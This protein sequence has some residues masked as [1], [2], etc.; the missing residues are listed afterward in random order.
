MKA[1]TTTFLIVLLILAGT[2]LAAGSLKDPVTYLG[3]TMLPKA[4]IVVSGVVVR[5]N[6]LSTGATL[7]RF[8]V[9]EVLHG[10]ERA[11]T[12]LLISPDP[13]QFPPVGVPVAYFLRRI[14]RERFE[15]AGRIELIGVEGPD[16]LGTLK[17]YLEIEALKDPQRKRRELHDYLMENLGAGR[18][19][20][21]W[22][23]ARELANF[24]KK[25]AGFFTREDIAAIRNKARISSEAMLKDLLADVIENIGDISR[26]LT[27]EGDSPPEPVEPRRPKLPPSSAFLK[28]ER[29]WKEGGLSVEARRMIVLTVCA[30]HLL[31]GGP[32]LVDALS[33]EDVEIR[34]LAAL[35]LGEAGYEPAAEPLLH[36]LGTEDDQ[37][38]IAAA[39]QSLGIL[40]VERARA[41]IIR[42]AEDK[43]LRRPVLFALARI[44]NEECRAFLEEVR[45]ALAGKTGDQAELRKLVDFLLSD[46]FRKQEDAL[47]KIRTRRLR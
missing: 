28:L 19:F 26:E 2:V 27:A 22:S 43:T 8:K 10:R 14:G 15:I 39:I 13:E 31:H 21:V 37:K 9:D 7:T 38:V 47:R 29:A 4:D 41:I 42:F 36:R 33:D 30:R 11:R 6:T 20:L 40:R 18:R 25:N 23:A 16:R 12:I 17:R 34:R 3:Q 44:D 24:T 35:N 32:L 46:D 45:S 1:G 5:S